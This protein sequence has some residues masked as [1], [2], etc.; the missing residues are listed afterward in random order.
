MTVIIKYHEDFKNETISSY[1][2]WWANDFGD[3]A[4]IAQESRDAGYGIYSAGPNP[5]TVGLK[6]AIQNNSPQSK[7]AIVMESK[8]VHAAMVMEANGVDLSEISP[9]IPGDKES[10]QFGTHLIPIPDINLEDPQFH[11]LQLQQVQLEFSGLDISDDMD[12]S[13]LEAHYAMLI[14]NNYP[15]DM[16]LGV[17]GLLRGDNSAIL[18]ILTSK[19]ID[20][21]TPLKDLA[22]A[23]Q[24]DVIIEAPVIDT[25]ADSSELLLAV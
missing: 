5:P 2:Y 13:F 20:V 16:N 22:V 25:V 21:N 17:Y 3:I 11:Q 24:F 18:K 1:T 15:N 19:G 7:A 10:L 9:I 4:D 8:G 23:S 6:I 12:I 14:D